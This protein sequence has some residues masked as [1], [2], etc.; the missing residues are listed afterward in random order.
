MDYPQLQKVLTAT[1]SMGMLTVL[2][3]LFFLGKNYFQK[4]VLMIIFI[5]EL[6]LTL[7]F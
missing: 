2:I 3:F 4:N 5:I 6:K 7:K 1:E